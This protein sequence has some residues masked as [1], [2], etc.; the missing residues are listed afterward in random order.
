MKSDIQLGDKIEWK[1][2]KVSD[3]FDVI[4]G[5]GVTRNEI[6]N[7]PGTI[8]AIQS[9]E[10]DMGCI[11]TISREYCKKK[12][13]RICEQ[14]CLTVARSGSSGFVGIQETPCIVGDSAKLLVPKTKM[15]IEELLY[16][17]AV[18]MVVKQKYCYDDKVSEKR[19]K[20]ETIILPK[21]ETGLAHQYIKK[22]MKIY[23]KKAQKIVSQYI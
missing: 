20:D 2:F 10:D 3:L 17:R 4:N 13:Y 11:G 21:T 14:P 6:L 18:L 16:I 1:P 7:N 5:V 19:Y 12:K 22:Q 15:S 8:R 9:G 23:Q